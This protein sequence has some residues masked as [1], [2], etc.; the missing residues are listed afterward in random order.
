[1]TTFAGQF[2]G[3]LVDVEADAVS[4]NLSSDDGV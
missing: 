3:S 2:S 1:M 4:T